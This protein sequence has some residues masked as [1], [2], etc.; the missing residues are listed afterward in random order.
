M[1]RGRPPRPSP[2]ERLAS[3]V[4]LFHSAG[5][6]VDEK[7]EFWLELVGTREATNRVL[8]DLARQLLANERR[9]RDRAKLS[10]SPGDR[11]APEPD[12]PAL[13]PEEAQAGLRDPAQGDAAPDSSGPP[14]AS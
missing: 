13:R 14:A 2:V 6:W 3:A 11:T 9:R 8:C 7:A 4:L 1:R 10:P 12:L 5:P